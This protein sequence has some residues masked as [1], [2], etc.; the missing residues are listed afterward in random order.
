MATEY[1]WARRP[2]TYA[3][4]DLDR[5][6]ILTLTGAR[7]DDKLTRLGYLDAYN[8]KVRDLVECT[9]C[10]AKFISH[11]ARIAH[12]EKRHRDRELTPHQ[13]DSRIDREEK[14]LEAV[15]PLHLDQTAASRGG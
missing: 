7:N 9:E 11:D 3:G 4:T 13:E 12:H 15:A 10:G 8:G 5:G 1:Y 2:F 14:M 6:Q